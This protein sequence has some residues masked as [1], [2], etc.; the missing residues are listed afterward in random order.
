MSKKIPISIKNIKKL[1]FTLDENANRG[2]YICLTESEYI[3]YSSI[4]NIVNQEKQQIINEYQ[5]NEKNNIINNFKKTEEYI[6]LKNKSSENSN[7]IKL[8]RLEAVNEFKKN[9]EYNKLL[10]AKEENIKLKNQIQVVKEKFYQSGEFKNKVEEFASITNKK[11]KQT[12]N[13][14]IENKQKE[15]KILEEQ[16]KLLLDKHNRVSINK[17]GKDLENYL[18]TELNKHF[19]INYPNVSF[20]KEEKTVKST[21]PDFIFE[22]KNN[23]KTIVKVV[24][25]AKSESNVSVNKTKNKD[26]YKKLDKDTNNRN[27]NYALLVTE[28][29]KNNDFSIKKINEYTNMFVIRP[30][31]FAS[32]LHLLYYFSIAL[33]KIISQ[34]NK[35]I[36]FKNKEEILNEFDNF[37]NNELTIFIT[38]I[39]DQ[40]VKIEKK[41]KDIEKANNAIQDI[42]NNLINIKIKRIQKKIHNF[43]IE[44]IANKI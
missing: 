21:K 19:G 28:L 24:I 23:N 15:V 34:S 17:I 22:V 36:N 20:Y 3:D 32:F 2:D 42:I 44:K 39:N 26:H 38:T 13:E 1:E 12:Y 7:N 4:R 9:D 25:E 29:E 10:L 37:K 5:T 35:E 41:S 40:V 18:E 16:Y 14:Q 31:Y 33:E 43:T 6:N 27:G 11:L 8:N 30:Q